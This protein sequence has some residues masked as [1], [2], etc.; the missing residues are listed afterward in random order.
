MPI[1][2]AADVQ[3]LPTAVMFIPSRMKNYSASER[4]HRLLHR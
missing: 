2:D 3:N 4:G 1:S